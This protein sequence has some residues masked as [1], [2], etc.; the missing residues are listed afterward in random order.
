VFRQQRDFPRDHAELGATAALGRRGRY[1]HGVARRDGF[2][3]A[4]QVQVGR[5]AAGIAE[6]QRMALGFCLLRPQHGHGNLVQGTAGET[7]PVQ[8]SGVGEWH[9]LVHA[10]NYVRVK[11]MRQ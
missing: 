3:A 7:A 5:L 8:E 2:L 1:S 6:D 11:L 9:G 4:T 10:A